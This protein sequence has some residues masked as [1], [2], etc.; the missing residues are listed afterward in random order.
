VTDKNDSAAKQIAEL[1]AQCVEINQD[2]DTAPAG[3]SIAHLWRGL[4]F[5]AD[6]IDRLAAEG[7]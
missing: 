4:M 1:M 3:V 6:R 5:L 7:T 2:N